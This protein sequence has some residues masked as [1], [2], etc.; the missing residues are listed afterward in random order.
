MSTGDK[1]NA[2][3]PTG[4][5]ARNQI[6]LRSAGE[7]SRVRRLAFEPTPNDNDDKDKGCSSQEDARKG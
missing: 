2:Q 5:D 4:Q 1:L 7:R 6:G 3:R